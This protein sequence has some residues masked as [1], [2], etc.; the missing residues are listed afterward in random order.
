MKKEYRACDFVK[1]MVTGL[2]YNSTKRFRITTSSFLHA[3]GINL[4]RGNVWGILENGKKIRLI[5]TN[6]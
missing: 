6:N 4:W 1:F 5:K 2:Y 3:T